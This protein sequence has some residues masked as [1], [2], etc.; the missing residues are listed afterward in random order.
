MVTV[1]FSRAEPLSYDMSAMPPLTGYQMRVLEQS[2]G[3]S[4]YPD[5]SS[6]KELAQCLELSESTIEVRID[7]LCEHVLMH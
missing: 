5:P 3:S 6:V 4:H 2:F 7:P 1:S